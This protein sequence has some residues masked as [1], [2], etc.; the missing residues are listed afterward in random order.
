MGV[1]EDGK[2]RYAGRV[3]TGFTEKTLD[4]LRQRLAPLRRDTSPF[5]RGVGG[6]CET[7]PREAVFVEP[8]SS[9]RSSSASG[10]PSG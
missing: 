7:V 5:E 6:A 3:G 1:Y 2:L 10:R 9:P 4:D 8:R